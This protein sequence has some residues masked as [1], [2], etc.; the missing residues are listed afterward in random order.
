MNK[1][2]LT[3]N[4]IALLTVLTCANAQ[5]NGKIVAQGKW[6]T[7]PGEFGLYTKEAPG[8]GP[9]DFVVS[10]RGNIYIAD[11]LNRRIV[12]YRNGKYLR[13][14]TTPTY[15]NTMA[16]DSK[17]NLYINDTEMTL[18]I[19]SLGNAIDSVRLGGKVRVDRDTAYVWGGNGNSC[20]F[21]L[22]KNGKTL[23]IV[24]KYTNKYNGSVIV[25]KGLEVERYGYGPKEKP[26]LMLI[27]VNGK[28]TPITM[29][30][31]GKSGDIKADLAGVFDFNSAM[32]YEGD[33]SGNVYFYH[34]GTLAR[35]NMK[36]EYTGI[37][38]P[39]GFC[40]INGMKLLGIPYDAADTRVQNGKVYQMRTLGYIEQEDKNGKKITKSF[41]FKKFVIMEY[42]FK[43][44]E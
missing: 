4:A 16:I 18:V 31:N 36:G 12:V 3:V 22:N 13:T 21:T 20:A 19:D 37:W 27:L 8:E 11:A 10:R 35:V 25:S 23:E 1:V 40:D 24:R 6:G 29:K 9:H 30:T 44:V 33:D 28:E 15:I 39:E 43:P 5:T 34:F 41:D 17:E 26:S 42:E 38:E 2:I 14:F 32:L 7:N